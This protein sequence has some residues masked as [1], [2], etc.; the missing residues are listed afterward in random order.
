MVNKVKIVRK[1]NVQDGDV[2]IGMD[3]QSNIFARCNTCNEN[4]VTTIGGNTTTKKIERS[5]IC[6]KCQ[7]RVKLY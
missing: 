3:A 6:K 1:Y 5:A 4:M 7:R 2:T